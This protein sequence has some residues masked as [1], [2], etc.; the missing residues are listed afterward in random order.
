MII[1]V[2]RFE[3]NGIKFSSLVNIHNIS[4]IVPF[5]IM[6]TNIHNHI[7][8]QIFMCDQSSFGVTE[9]IEQIREMIESVK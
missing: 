8:S 3:S 9:T 5:N 2:T 7:G 1:T 6:V 4:Y